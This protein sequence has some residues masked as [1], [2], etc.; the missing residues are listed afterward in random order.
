M[1]RFLGFILASL[2]VVSLTPGVRAQD[3]Q[4]PAGPQVQAQSGLEQKNYEAY[5][6]GELYVKGEKLPTAQEVTQTS[7][8]TQEDI[9]AA[10]SQNVADAL[11]HVPGITITTGAKNQPSVSLQGLNQTETLV[12]IDGV[13]YYETNYGLL[14]L[15]TIPVDMIDHIEVTKGRLIGVVRAEQPR[16]R[17]QHHHEEADGEAFPRCSSAEY[18]DYRADEESVSHGMKVGMLSYWF[19]YDRQDSK[20]WYLSNDFEPQAT[21]LCTRAG[22]K[23]LPR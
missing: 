21:N 7:V 1:R 20:G 2:M 8:V 5:D 3:A 12:L 17:H 14:N 6:L 13:P 18:G 16:G 23:R 15:K 4:A 10:H 9:E 22:G 19:G 11:S